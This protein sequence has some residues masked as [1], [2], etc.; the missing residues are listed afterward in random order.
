MGGV[1]RD[2]AVEIVGAG[3]VDLC[4][5]EV[6][7]CRNVAAVRERMKR[8]CISLGIGCDHSGL[9]RRQDMVGV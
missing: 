9:S 3:V 4:D 8:D 6:V 1:R 5:N 7:G 2:D